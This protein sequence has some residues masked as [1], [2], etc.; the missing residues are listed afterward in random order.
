MSTP[1]LRTPDSRFEGLPDYPWAP[2]YIEIKDNELGPLRMH[3]VVDGPKDGPVAL[4]MHG[5]P[6]WSYLYR[7]IIP[8]F[9]AAGF[10]VYAP[11][12][13]GFGKS[14]K[15]AQTKDYSY[16][17]HVDWVSQFVL[18]LGLNDIRLL[19]QDWGGLIG[20][21]VVTAF[22]ERFSAIVTANTGLPDG[23]R[24]MPEAF[25]QWLAYS[26]SLPD[27][28]VGEVLQRGT[29]SILP[30]EVVAAYNAPFPDASFKAGSKAFPALVPLTP[31]QPAALDNQA[32]WKILETWHKPWLTAFSDSDPVTKGGEKLFQLR[33]PGAFG[34]THPTL[35]GGGH[36]LQ[37]D[38]PQELA[39]VAIQLFN[40]IKVKA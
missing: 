11:D 31:T 17:K 8:L 27:M 33:I 26:Q 4:L 29:V 5:E 34:R 1:V 3:Y 19:C 35:V 9:V 14:D 6:S 24:P 30:D 18:G 32:A 40:E 13:I 12:L 37:E 38:V 36:F 16:A 21:R 2:N 15:P 23:M 20:L 10:R 28:P 7:K 25:L 22:P 39:D